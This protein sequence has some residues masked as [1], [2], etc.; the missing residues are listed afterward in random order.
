MLLQLGKK[1]ELLKNAIKVVGLL[2]NKSS[3]TK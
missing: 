1:K 3:E 2:N